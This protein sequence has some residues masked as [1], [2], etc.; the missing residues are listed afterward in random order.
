M[1]EWP[2]LGGEDPPLVVVV[3]VA[4]ELVVSCSCVGDPLVLGTLDNR[5]VPLPETLW[6]GGAEMLG[7]LVP[8]EERGIAAVTWEVVVGCADRDVWTLS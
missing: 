5:G 1:G 3:V 8:P 7:L 4:L 6:G 2:F